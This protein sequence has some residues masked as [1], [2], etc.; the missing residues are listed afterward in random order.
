MTVPL[1]LDVFS[2][3]ACPWCFIGKR[4]MAK[5]L[6]GRSD[7]Q[8]QWRAYQ[9]MPDLPPEGL[10]AADYFAKR[11]GNPEQV[12]PMFE[13]VEAL[14]RAE[15]LAFDLAGR[16]RL[17]N[18]RLAHRV[19]QLC[20]GMETGDAAVEALFAGQFLEDADVSR[21][22]VIL[23]LLARHA[24]A[25]DRTKLVMGLGTDGGQRAVES[26]LV[27]AR[28]LGITGVPTFVM[29]GAGISGAQEVGTFRA[30]LEEAA[31]RPASELPSVSE[32]PR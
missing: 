31:K 24:P 8:V 20:E 23:D 9:L 26:D 12:K 6:E 18:T 4:R 13:R 11:F 29:N 17:V 28:R 19:I 32:S 7:V 5:A 25:V 10:D 21:L 27:L 15:G 2:D 3:I 30:F 22:D 14:A 16:K 1:V